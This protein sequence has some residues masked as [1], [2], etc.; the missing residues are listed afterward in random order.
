AVITG[1]VLETE[2]VN[3][4]TELGDLTPPTRPSTEIATD[5]QVAADKRDAFAEVVDALETE[6]ASSDDPTLAEAL[7]KAQDDLAAA[8]AE[9]D[10]LQ[11]DLVDAQAYEDKE[12]EVAD[13]TERAAKNEQDQ[14]D[15]L[16]AAANKEVTPEVE[17]TVQAM[18]GLN[19][20]TI[21]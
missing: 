8:Q 16:D 11:N 20:E 1:R 3:A 2:L 6:V 14:A 21:E 4:E 9:A 17:A 19:E 10:A 12:Q 7:S 18:L 15:L 13:L 5:L